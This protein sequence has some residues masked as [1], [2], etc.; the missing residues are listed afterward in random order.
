MRDTY[1][2][3]GESTAILKATAALGK[4]DRGDT[5]VYNTSGEGAI[6]T[7]NCGPEDIE[8]VL[9]FPGVKVLKFQNPADG[10]SALEN[11]LKS[12]QDQIQ[13]LVLENHRQR[14]EKESLARN[15]GEK[16]RLG[17]KQSREQLDAL[18][19]KLA[20]QYGV[21]KV[22]ATRASAKDLETYITIIGSS[23][24]KIIAENNAAYQQLKAEYA[25]LKESVSATK[26]TYT[27]RAKIADSTLASLLGIPDEQREAVTE[28]L[29]AYETK[30]V[31][32]V[33]RGVCLRDAKDL[34]G[35][36]PDLVNDVFAHLELNL[37]AS[38]KQD[39]VNKVKTYLAGEGEWNSSAWNSEKI[40][41]VQDV[42]LAYG[43][44]AS[45]AAQRIKASGLSKKSGSY[46]W[47]EIS[48]A[49][50]AD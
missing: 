31:E 27:P 23:A 10:I 11:E 44:S 25:D 21:Q 35:K 42:A 34:E 5:R 22:D 26:P 4:L 16:V 8:G 48:S 9:T 18:L 15:I 14:T 46:S 6:I 2:L 29:E 43:K 28:M 20:E 1:K 17:E 36:L 19:G 3:F 45:W 50:K 41:N 38:Q 47:G 37:T 33:G 12:A 13:K 40:V 30:V 24:Q 7:T 32:V 39:Y 49:F